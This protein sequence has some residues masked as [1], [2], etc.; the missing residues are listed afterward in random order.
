M[1]GIRGEKGLQGIQGV[2]GKAGSVGAVG[3][4]G[5]TGLP[6]P[7]GA[8]GGQGVRG[9]PGSP[10][11]TGSQGIRGEIGPAGIDGKT[12][13]ACTNDNIM[14]MLAQY[15]SPEL[16]DNYKNNYRYIGYQIHK[17]SDVALY[18]PDGMY[19]VKTIYNKSGIHGPDAAQPNPIKMAVLNWTEHLSRAVLQEK[20]NRLHTF[21]D[22]FIGVGH[23]VI[24]K[25]YFLNFQRQ[26]W[27]HIPLK[28]SHMIVQQHLLYI[29]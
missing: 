14:R 18:A 6:G 3:P 23:D 1:P 10:G 9:I 12:G 19:Q 4:Q 22:Q 20:K 25:R 28:T 8:I 21:Q 2:G 24:T 13:K 7:T 16:V 5:I 29:D 15:V 17:E 26:A 27:Y 11:V